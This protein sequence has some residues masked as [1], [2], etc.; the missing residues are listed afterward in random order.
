MSLRKGCDRFF[1]Q[2]QR[3]GDVAG[4]PG[5]PAE[6]GSR[7]RLEQ[8]HPELGVESDRSSLV[9]ERESDIAA[10]SEK[11][12]AVVEGLGRG[13]GLASSDEAGDPLAVGLERVVDATEVLQDQGALDE[14]ARLQRPLQLGVR[15]RG[16]GER[17]LQASLTIE[18]ESERH[19][20]HALGV[21][22]V[23]TGRQVGRPTQPRLGRMQ[24]GDVG[25]GE[26]RDPVGHRCGL[27][28][29]TRR[30][31]LRDLRDD[32]VGGGERGRRVDTDQVIG[33]TSPLAEVLT[34]R[35][36]HLPDHRRTHTND[37]GA[38]GRPGLHGLRGWSAR[39]RVRLLGLV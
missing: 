10:E 20:R 7:L 12:R 18:R 1:H 22:E 4:E 37:H 11:V 33:G 38:R 27:V 2:P 16:G 15:P 23:M 36:L 31:L 21:V 34:L 9:V 28:L 19:L 8:R 3:T 25:E 30:P 26:A 35:R 5:Q 39:C 24:V 29:L 14:V 13:E 17:R 32:G 6:V